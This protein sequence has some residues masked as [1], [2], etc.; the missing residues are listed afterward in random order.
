LIV[1]AAMIAPVLIT[2]G[3]GKFLEHGFTATERYLSA[4]RIDHGE[5]LVTFGT[6]LKGVGAGVVSPSL[7]WQ[8]L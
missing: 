4:A 2:G 3:M 8:S 1:S 5:G 7:Y 6:L